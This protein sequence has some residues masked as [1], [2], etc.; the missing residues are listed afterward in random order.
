[1]AQARR[2]GLVAAL[3]VAALLLTT[4]ARRFPLDSPATLPVA[5]LVTLALCLF[6]GYTLWLWRNQTPPWIEPPLPAT[7]QARSWT[8]EHGTVLVGATRAYA[9]AERHDGAT[10]AA[11]RHRVNPHMLVCGPSG[12]GKTATMRWFIVAL[13]QAGY[14]LVIIDGKGGGAFAGLANLERVL[15]VAEDPGDWLEATYLVRDEMR[16]RYSALRAWRYGKGDPP[17]VRPI[18]FVVDELEDVCTVAGAKFT[19]PLFEIAR[20]GREAGGRILASILRPD[21]STIPGKVRDSFT[22]RVFMGTLSH[23]SGLMMFDD[24]ADEAR[25]A[26]A[27]ASDIPGRGVAMLAGRI[28]P[29]QV[30]WVADPADDPAALSELLRSDDVH[31]PSGARRACGRVEGVTGPDR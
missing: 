17:D 3:V 6:L 11:W 28:H 16:T 9:G 29:I 23:T 15:M 21:T 27:G 31:D 13:L 2:Y 18:A 4:V 8:P 12:A 24:K 1:M 26:S 19:D 14:D 5:T 7:V 30:P 10:F 20:M 22:G 25:K